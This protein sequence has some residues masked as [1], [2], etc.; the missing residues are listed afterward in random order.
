MELNKDTIKKVMGLICFAAVVVLAVI[1]F[2]V[3]YAYFWNV[4]GILYPFL[5]GGAIAFVINLPMRFYEKH[6]FDNAW[7]KKSKLSPLVKVKRP[8]S[9]VLALVSVILVIVLVMGIVIPQLFNTVQTLAEKFP[10][11]IEDVR[12]LL[13]TLKEDVPEVQKILTYLNPKTVDWKEL[14]GA[15]MDFLRNGAGENVL[16]STFSIAGKAINGTVNFFI[17]LV[18]A[19]YILVQKEKLGNQFSR[20]LKAY[21]S[22]KV[23][24]TTLKVCSMLHGNFSKFIVGQCTEAVILGTLFVVSMTVFRF[25][26][27]LMIGVLIAFTSLIPIVGAFIGCI[28]GAFLLLVDDPVRAVLFVVLFLVIQQIEGNLIY[29]HVVGNSVGLPS[30]WVLAAVTVGGSLMGV[31]GMLVFIPLMSTVYALLR[32][33]VNQRNAGK[34]AAVKPPAGQKQTAKGGK[35]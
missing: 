28:V 2:D 8:C 19:I 7:I 15:V 27:A 25:E 13:E 5:L 23:Y 34:S 16:A 18:F 3:L 26:Y 1:K 33:S 11:F 9:L 31:V 30:I 24:R 4:A 32:E 35:K 20:L 10:I 12:K 22:E 29:P 6:L 14:M 17:A 21:T